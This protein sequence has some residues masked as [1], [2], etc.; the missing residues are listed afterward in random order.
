MKK[1]L[2]SLTAAGVLV[3]G[4]AA[5]SVIT[6]ST[7]DAQEAP[8][9]E[10]TTT[11]TTEERPTRG[12]AVQEVL[13]ELVAAGEITQAQ[14]DTIQGALEAKWEELG[15]DR[16]HHRHGKAFR[17][18]FRLGGLLEDGVV[19]ADELAGLPDDHPFKDAD[20]PFA[21]AAADG[22]LTEDEI[23]E[24][25]EQLREDGELPLRRGFRHGFGGTAPEAEGT[26][27]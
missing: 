7:A 22:E 8:A 9:D 4:V 1:I 2:V 13:D 18:G 26:S 21:D 6:S 12:A 23:R 27:V 16:P 10:E 17:H 14:A 25:V 11:T 19:D 3:A 20:G 15:A 24:V 5:A